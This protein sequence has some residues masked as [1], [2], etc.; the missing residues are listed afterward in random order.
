MG[1]AQS[2]VIKNRFTVRG[3]GGE[4]SRGSTPGNY[5]E[6]YMGRGEAVES[7]LP[8]SKGGPYEY[9]QRYVAREGAVLSAPDVESA[10]VRGTKSGSKD[11]VAFGMGEVSLSEQSFKQLS[12]D[13]QRIFD[14]GDPVLECVLS[15]DT[16]YLRD[17]G[18][19]DPGTQVRRKGDLKGHVDQLRL[20]RAIMEGMDALSHRFDNMVWVGC[21]QFDTMHVHAHLA[22]A[23]GDRE[24]Q[25]RMRPD[26]EHRGQ[27]S[28]DE[29]R[30]IRRGVDRSLDL[31]KTLPHLTAA[32]SN[33]RQNVRGFVRRYAYDALERSGDMQL[34]IASL[35]SDSKLWRAGSH[36]RDMRRA[37]ELV[38][39]F[40]ERA[41]ADPASGYAAAEE[42]VRA[43]AHA[44][45]M[46]EGGDA[47]R[48][49]EL[50]ERGLGR[51]EDSCVN[52]V[53]AEIA[54]WQNRPVHTRAIDVMASDI[55]E[56][57]QLS[58]ESDGNEFLFR[59]RTYGGRLTD[60]RERRHEAHDN[61][62]AWEDRRDH[63]Q[64]SAAS[65]AMYRYYLFEERYQTQVM[66]KYQSL[67]PLSL[68]DSNL[69][70]EL[71]ALED[72][73]D[74]VRRM[75][76][77]LTD[78]RMPQMRAEDAEAYGRDV[79]HV[80]GGAWLVRSPSVFVG[81]IERARQRLHEHAAEVGFDFADV[82]RLV[83][84]SDDTVHVSSGLAYPFSETRGLDLHR[85]R[86]DFDDVWQ[87]GRDA[88]ERFREATIERAH[89][90]QDA[91][92]Y[93]I[94]SG[95]GSLVNA[96]L[97]VREVEQMISCARSVLQSGDLVSARADTLGR[98]PIYTV[99][100]EPELDERA[101]MVVRERVRDAAVDVL[102]DIREEMV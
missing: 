12:R 46:R 68:L 49:Q 94:G 31:S 25:K 84:V 8:V 83:A 50:I 13:I 39:G 97:P 29:R 60:A 80:R 82:G 34:I 54:E 6:R 64:A 35:P 67:F 16:E 100:T 45:V 32:I 10:E 88:Q 41:L 87:V 47:S 75:Q 78:E 92:N 57:A 26:G 89:V 14:E 72:E 33:Q 43:Y 9:L 90:V 59:L 20:R 30:L 66:A 56:A 63:N 91:A 27:L 44:S 24:G 38:R 15:F 7:C 73:A 11:G 5:V 61:A 36:R 53:Y 86:Y 69:T 19:L 2:I 65:E 40:V 85:M 99:R 1:L 55:M 48:E 21:L 70:D 81:R 62:R 23:E 17:Q 58:H 42:Q 74:M 22:I 4:G 101:R 79:Y 95:Q 98:T 96:T 52:G 18:L 77:M 76:T 37:N 71:K 93:L 51:I 28:S 102:R 3:P